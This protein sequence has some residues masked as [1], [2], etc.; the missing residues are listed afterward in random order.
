MDHI[1]DP[2]REVCIC[3]GYSRQEI[4]ERAVPMYCRGVPAYREYIKGSTW[5]REPIVPSR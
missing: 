1:F 5:V 4:V 2:R 3:C